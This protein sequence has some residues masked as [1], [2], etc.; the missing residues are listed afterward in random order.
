[1]VGDD[2]ADTVYVDVKAKMKL[3]SLKLVI[4]L[5]TINKEIQALLLLVVVLIVT[6][7]GLQRIDVVDDIITRLSDIDGNDDDG[8][9]DK[10]DVGKDFLDVIDE[11]DEFADV[12]IYVEADVS[13][14]LMW[15]NFCSLAG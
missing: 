2:H 11:A 13:F 14:F 15:E 6:L 10:D 1:M 8:D 9:D 12:Q 4:I 7:L 3:W 5:M